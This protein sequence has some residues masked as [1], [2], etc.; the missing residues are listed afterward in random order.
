MR[1]TEKAI[2]RR[3]YDPSFQQRYFVGHG[4]DIGSGDTPLSSFRQH[5]ERME[6]VREWD[7]GDGDAQVL[8]SLPDAQF[9]F[10]HSSH[11]LEHMVDPKEALQNWIRVLK[12]G[13]YLV[14]TVPDEDLYE[15]SVWPSRFN[16]DHKWSFTICKRPSISDHSL[17]VVD[18]LHELA[19][20]MDCERLQQLREHYRED[21]GVHVDQTLGEAE[22]AIEWVWRKRTAPVERTRSSADWYEE[23]M[24]SEQAGELAHAEYAYTKACNAHPPLLAPFNNLAHLLACQRRYADVERVWQEATQ[25]IPGKQTRIFQALNLMQ[26]GKY[27]EGFR[28]RE[29]SISDA[30][31]ARVLPDLDRPRWLGERLTGKSIAIWTEFG[32]GDEIMFSR[33]APVFKHNLGAARVSV[34]C[35]DPIYSLLQEGLMDTDLVLP[36]SRVSELPPH[37]YWVF[38]HSI[39][40]YASLNVSNIPNATYLSV[41][42]VRQADWAARL[43]LP[44]SQL[45]VGVVWQGDPTHENDANRSLASLQVLEPLLG[46]KGVHFISLQKGKGEGEAA[47]R[48]QSSGGSFTAIGHE[49]QDFADTAAVI[50]Q[51]DLVITV[52]TSVAHL[53]G[54]MGKTTWLMLPTVCDWRWLYECEDSPWYP[55]MRIFRQQQL[56]Q[57]SPVLRRM[58]HKLE[59]WSQGHVQLQK[60]LQI[61]ALAEAH[62]A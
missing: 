54:A 28:L 3:I 18:L 52:D 7:V 27:R 42:G 19:E 57:W 36:V 40:L 39:P 43:G 15:H 62:V 8:A 14:V 13:G 41:S 5:F 59:G 53:A 55:S 26:M 44:A 24:R 21:A 32:L 60:Q 31:R 23:A 46:I 38:P 37:D 61:P 20:Q 1:E 16:S 12:P 17:N 50:A 45:S 33:F 29:A 49:L 35:Q 22:C 58:A 34:L 9:D 30:R 25:R 51:L 11:C 6:S 10:V 56:G 48:A 47:E 4:I 2:R